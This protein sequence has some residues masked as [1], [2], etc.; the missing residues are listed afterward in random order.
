MSAHQRSGRPGERP[1]ARYGSETSMLTRTPKWQ[2]AEL[3]APSVAVQDTGVNPNR[4][5]APGRCVHVI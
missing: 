1:G 2:E 4:N 5:R 3:P